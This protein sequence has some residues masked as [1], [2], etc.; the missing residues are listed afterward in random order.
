VNLDPSA[1]V[2]DMVLAMNEVAAKTAA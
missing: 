2:I 1:L